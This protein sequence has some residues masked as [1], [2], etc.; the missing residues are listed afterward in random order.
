VKRVLQLIEDAE[1][2]R[3]MGAQGLV[4]AQRYRAENIMQ[5]WDELYKS[6]CYHL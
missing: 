1:L 6:F 2:R 3:Q 4:S 5:Q